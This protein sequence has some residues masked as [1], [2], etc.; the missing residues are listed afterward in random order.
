MGKGYS[1]S[2]S[3]KARETFKGHLTPILKSEIVPGP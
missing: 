3:W 1:K 2:Q